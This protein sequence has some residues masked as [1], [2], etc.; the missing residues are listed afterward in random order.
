MSVIWCLI[1][2]LVTFTVYKLRSDFNN[3]VNAPYIPH[4]TSKEIKDAM[5]KMGPNYHY[6]TE[7]KKLYVNRGDGKWLRLNYKRKEI[8]R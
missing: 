3:R 5:R 7:G 8:R 1:S 4:Q 2:G 6:K